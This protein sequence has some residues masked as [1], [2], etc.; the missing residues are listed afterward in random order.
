MIK[1]GI[2][3]YYSIQDHETGKIYYESG[4]LVTDVGIKQLLQTFSIK[5][6][7]HVISK[8]KFGDGE[9]NPSKTDTGLTN[10][11]ESSTGTTVTVDTANQQI[12]LK[13]TFQ[14]SEINQKKEVGVFTDNDV[15]FTRDVLS[16]T[17][18]I[19]AGSIVDVTYKLSFNA[20]TH[21]LNW[22]ET[23]SGSKKYSTTSNVKP[24]AIKQVYNNNVYYFTEKT[25]TE[26]LT[27]EGTYYY[28]TDE[29]TIYIY[30]YNSDT[31]AIYL[32]EG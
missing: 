3:G 1:I 22:K 12:I 8:L 18:S 31:T 24:Y 28:N 23:S 26:Q 13:S 15:L 30:P 17:I 9:T 25:S 14:Y 20:S 4:N 32:I 6:E 11:V 29:K 2:Q 7:D 19:P 10:A 5:G 27:S 21:L 16:D